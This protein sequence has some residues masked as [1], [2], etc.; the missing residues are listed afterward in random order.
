MVLLTKL[1]ESHTP[2]SAILEFHVHAR[3][4]F[5]CFALSIFDARYDTWAHLVEGEALELIPSF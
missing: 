1:V 5:P 4:D 3:T 2:L